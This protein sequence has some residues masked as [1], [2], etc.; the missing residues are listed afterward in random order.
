M[1]KS[2]KPVELLSA[3]VLLIVCCG[4]KV[5]AVTPFGTPMFCALSGA[6]FIGFVAPVYLLCAFLFTFEVWRL[7]TAGAVIFIMA[8][9]WFAGLKLPRCDR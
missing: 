8:V 7:Y 3:A 5:Y 9:R 1:K 6:F 4:G 2:V